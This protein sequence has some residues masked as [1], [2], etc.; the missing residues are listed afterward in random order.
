MAH[1]REESTISSSGISS[2]KTL[3]GITRIGRMKRRLDWELGSESDSECCL[4]R[5]A[6]ITLTELVAQYGFTESTPPPTPSQ[7]GKGTPTTQ[8]MWAPRIIIPFSFTVTQSYA[9]HP[10]DYLADCLVR[11]A[12]SG[13][14]QRVSLACVCFFIPHHYTFAVRRSALRL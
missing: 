1:P 2:P 13:A 11:T 3:D 4:P 5:L 9:V 7:I 6:S 14:K 12:Q 10:S 8:L